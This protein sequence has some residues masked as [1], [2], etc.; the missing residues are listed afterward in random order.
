MRVE[1]NKKLQA[2]LLFLTLACLGSLTNAT[3][4]EDEAIP[5]ESLEPLWIDQEKMDALRYAPVVEL[6]ESVNINENG[7]TEY[8]WNS[9]SPFTVNDKTIEEHEATLSVASKLDFSLDTEDHPRRAL[10][11]T[12]EQSNECKACI[13]NTFKWCPT[14]NYQS[15]YCCNEFETC[16][17]A[18]MC[19]DEFQFT[20]IM[21]MLCPNELGCLF[22]RT[23]VPPTN[24]NEKLYENI[25]GKFQL[26]DL[27]SYKIAIPSSTDLNDMMYLRIE[28]LHNAKATLIKGYNLLDP[29]AMY[30]LDEGHNFSAT[31]DIN[32]FLLFEATNISSGDFV[33]KIWYNNVSGSG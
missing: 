28:Y 10:Y 2:S 1:L 33:F 18:V 25:E 27:C 23:L 4:M 19:S 26:G 12:T 7:I 32:F 9:R 17:R 14:S 13:D 22:A 3:P 15:G 21:Y 31:K 29:I 11:N 6:E 24:G 16:P 20:E 8:V 5:I 30:S